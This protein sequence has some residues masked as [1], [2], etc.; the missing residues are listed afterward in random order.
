MS[1]PARLG[2]LAAALLLVWPA[3]A[4][5]AGNRMVLACK[6]FFVPQTEAAPTDGQP[7]PPEPPLSVRF[8]IAQKARGTIAVTVRDAPTNPGVS[9][10]PGGPFAW[11]AGT[12]L[13]TL[14]VKGRLA[15]G[16]AYVL[17]HRLDQAQTQ[18]PPTGLLTQLICEI[19]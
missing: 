14:T 13:N 7:M 9:A 8:T 18:V 2:A 1:R 3:A 10:G 15:D 5:A 12:E 4:P 11:A 19:S 6:A 16:R 17:W